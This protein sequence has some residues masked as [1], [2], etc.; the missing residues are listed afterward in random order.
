[1]KITNL[2]KQNARDADL[3]SF[4][5][6]KYP[7]RLKKCGSYWR[8]GDYPDVTIWYN[9]PYEQYKFKAHAQKSQ[10]YNA[11]VIGSDTIAYVRKFLDY[12]FTEAVEELCKYP[13]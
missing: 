2:M 10:D 5:N 8:D 7:G 4:M 6:E 3:I 9:E 13:Q 11:E 12:S 1:M